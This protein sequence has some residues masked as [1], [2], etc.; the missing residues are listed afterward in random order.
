[1]KFLRR[2][3]AR[4][5][6]SISFVNCAESA[7]QYILVNDTYRGYTA[8]TFTATGMPCLTTALLQEWGI[9][10]ENLLSLHF[11][12]AGC[13]SAQSLSA[14]K[15][16]YYFDP[17]PQVLTLY[18]PPEITSPV[19]NGVATSRWD[20]GI[21]AAF[22]DYDLS[23]SHFTGGNYH[24]YPRQHSLEMTT[25]YGA[26]W[27]PWRLRY[28]PVYSKEAYSNPTWH[29]ES[30]MA[31][32]TIR[33]LRSLLTL[34]DSNTSS[35]MF[36]SISY[37]GIS[38][39]SDDRMLP[40]EMRPLS[41]WIRGF[42]HGKAQVKIRQYGTVIYHTTV[43]PGAFI[44][45]DIYP[46]DAT[47]DI[48]MTI[49]ESDGTE[50]VRT[51]P[52]S[53]M[54]NI[55]HSGQWKFALSAGK[56]RPWYTLEQQ[57]PFF[58]QYALSY[59]LPGNISLFGSAMVSGIWQ[60]GVLGIGKRVDGWGA[61]SM[62]LSYTN[63]K[64]PRRSNPDR[65]SMARLRY[66]H[67]FSEWESSFSLTARYYPAQRYRTFS[68]AVSQQEKYW[69]D[70]EDG[71]FTGEFDAEK[72]NAI[73]ISYAQNIA[74]DGEL[75]LT[76]TNEALRGR[77]R[78]ETSLEL[79]YTARWNKIDYAAYATWNRPDREQEEGRITFSISIPF[80]L[81]SSQRIKLNM[82]NT[83]AKNGAAS[84]KVGVSGIALDDYSLGYNL[85]TTRQQ[86]TGNSQN[87]T[88]NYQYNAG[89]LMA[90]YSNKKQESTKYLGLT[91][92]IVAHQAGI[93]LG[94]TLG[95]TIAIV[96]AE[97]TANIGLINQFGSTTDSRGFAVISSLTPYRVNELLLDTFSL[98]PGKALSVGEREVVPTAGA[99]MYSRFR[100]EPEKP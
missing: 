88:L 75:W 34:G 48:E 50:T 11:S 22:I 79:G 80:T 84:R 27:G 60:G 59:G 56:Y 33:S 20:D 38:L 1:M 3:L 39:T 47:A 68:E 73:A 57:E 77:N 81:F 2:L 41:P 44:L 37:R 92:S 13:A 74:E 63:A 95:E 30:A 98:P 71:V 65:G 85:S 45:K 23:Y 90:V 49:R 55:V 29:T 42:A 83:L 12:P 52:W 70:W 54:P 94:Q 100:I 89:E 64:D 5:V 15:I 31:F 4:I 14:K 36:D 78:R 28:Q 40:D 91:G 19:T 8:L 10:Q 53:A 96:D 86:G 87:I 58:S 21:N 61:L 9:R 7:S 18:I 16:R 99:V 51:I 26:N 6:L 93:T 69:W 35:D 76:L 72:K 32:R 17:R 43:P 62:D 46:M 25:T 97:K 82:E 67:A 66:T 24:R